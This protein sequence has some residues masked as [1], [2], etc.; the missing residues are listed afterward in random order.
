MPNFVRQL[1]S[2][3]PLTSINPALDQQLRTTYAG[4]AHWAGSGP[5]GEWCRN[6]VFWSW[7]NR[8]NNKDLSARPCVRYR[9]LTGDTKP[10]TVPHDAKACRHF[11]S[12][13][14][15]LVRS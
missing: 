9:E 14:P 7:A 6:C 4:Q 3:I 8:S 2:S 13:E 5:Q 11:E 1:K 10:K 12:R 15:S